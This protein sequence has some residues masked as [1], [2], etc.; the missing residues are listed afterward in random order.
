MHNVDVIAQKHTPNPIGESSRRVVAFTLELLRGQ[1][2]SPVFTNPGIIVG[3][4]YEHTTV[5]PM[6]IQKLEERNTLLV[7]EE[8]KIL[9]NYVEHCDPS[10]YGWT[11]V[12]TW[13]VALP[14]PS[15]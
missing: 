14:H 3:L 12:Y 10:K 5:E 9:K 11:A 6:V 8:G 7:T 13:D 15:R 4:V 1:P 2:L